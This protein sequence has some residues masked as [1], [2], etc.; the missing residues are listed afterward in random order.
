M[1]WH[2][3]SKNDRMI[4]VGTGAGFPGVPMAIMMEEIEMTLL[5]SLNKRVHFLDEVV[6]ALGL[7]N[8]KTQ[9]G[10]AEDYGS[11]R[12]WRECFDSAISRAV[13][14]I[15]VLSEYCLPFVRIGGVFLAMK[16]SQIDEELMV[17]EKAIKVLGGEIEK[18]EKYQLSGYDLSRSLVT[19][20]KVGPTPKQYP[21]KA[22]KPSKK[23]L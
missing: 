8:V 2:E 3:L 15:N 6:K 21:R 1:R 11:N 5:D 7:E 20:R 4:D 14:P 12:E 17:G 9:H 10:R 19:I 18:V 22:G 23:P 16:S 13:A